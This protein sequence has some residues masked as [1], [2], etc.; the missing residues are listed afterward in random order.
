[1][2]I[3]ATLRNAR[4]SPTGPWRDYDHLSGEIYG[5]V[6]MRFVDGEPITTSQ[7]VK[8]LPGDVFVTRN[9][10]YKVESWAGAVPANDDVPA[11]AR[12]DATSIAQERA[13]IRI[14][15]EICAGARP[16]AVQVL[17]WADEL[18]KAEVND[19]T[20]DGPPEMLY[21]AGDADTGK[22]V[23]F[24]PDERP[25]DYLEPAPH[26]DR[27]PAPIKAELV[28]FWRR[29]GGVVMSVVANGAVTDYAIPTNVLAA[30]AR[31]AIEKLEEMAAAA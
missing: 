5:D 2:T 19:N 14:S 6:R 13:A 9:S 16:D 15:A 12:F 23:A 3:T 26:R 31:Y 1:M 8:A 4:R 22:E 25:G 18:Y 30:G 11:S 21:R 7:I 17:E 20:P 27:Y 24:Y 29:D 10:T 28:T